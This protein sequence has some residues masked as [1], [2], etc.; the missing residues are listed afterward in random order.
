[1]RLTRIVC[2]PAGTF[3]MSV[4]PA[5][6]GTVLVRHEPASGVG[7]PQ[8]SLLDVQSAKLKPV[9]GLGRVA[10]GAVR[11]GRLWLYAADGLTLKI[12]S[13]TPG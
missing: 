10:V 3:V 12:W 5:E 8:W 6:R 4:T 11:K 13:A 2:A 1:M 9:K 7:D